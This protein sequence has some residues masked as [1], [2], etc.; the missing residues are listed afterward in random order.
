MK[1]YEFIENYREKF[2]VRRLCAMM[3]V[4]S[5]GYYAWRACPTSQRANENAELMIEIADVHRESRKNYLQ[6]GTD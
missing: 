6:E 1:R 2:P 3:R 5:S 4:S